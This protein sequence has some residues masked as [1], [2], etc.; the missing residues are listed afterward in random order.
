[1]ELERWSLRTD[2]STSISFLDSGGP[3]PEVVILHGL[4]G[5]STEFVQTAKALPRY[6][7]LI[8]DQRGHGHSTRRPDDTSRAAF[9]RDCVRVIEAKCRSAVTLVGQSMGAHTAMLA[10]ASRPDLV[11]R[12]VLLEGGA[13]SGDPI[14]YRKLGDFFRSW[15]TPF[16]DRTAARAFLGDGPLERAWVADLE[17]LTDGLYPRFD[18]DVMVSTADA[19]AIPRWDA[20]QQ[21]PAP[22]LVVYAE[23]GMF[24]EEQK[25]A[26]VD[27]GEN[28]TRVNIAGASHDAHLDAFDHWAGTLRSFLEAG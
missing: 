27:A 23:N 16:R 14:A 3:G 12:L 2:D 25:A 6:R 11:E 10:A 22:T 26:F 7:T 17:E 20:W 9:V 4:A 28:V 1:M 24:S 19:L 21:V 5:S 8:V 13:G 18:P 15:P